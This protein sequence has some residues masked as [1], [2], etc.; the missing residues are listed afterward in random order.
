MDQSCKPLFSPFGLTLQQKLLQ[1]RRKLSQADR[2]DETGNSMAENAQSKVFERSI[3]VFDWLLKQN[4]CDK[5]M[6]VE[7]FELKFELQKILAAQRQ[8]GGVAKLEK[9]EEPVADICG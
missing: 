6:E 7:V 8:Y 9:Q 2:T 4:I 1:Q 3:E 5:R